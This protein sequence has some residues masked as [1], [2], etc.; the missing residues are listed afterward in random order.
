MDVDQTSIAITALF[1]EDIDKAAKSFGT[2]DVV[3]SRIE[4]GL[5]I[6]SVV[7]RKEKLVRKIKKKF[8]ANIEAEGATKEEEEEDGSEE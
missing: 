6:A 7:K 3:K 5:K 2:Y 1:V 8:G 4:I